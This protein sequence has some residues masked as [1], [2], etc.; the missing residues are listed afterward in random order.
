[1]MDRFGRPVTG[2]RISLA[3][4]S[5]CNF[6]CV[7]CHSEGIYEPAEPVMRPQ[8]IERIVRIAH[9]L[10]VDKVKLTGG[11]PMLRP[12]I[13][14]IVGRV[15]GV[16][17]TDLSMT[18][19]GT[20]LARLAGVLREKGLDRVNIS[21]HSLREERYTFITNTHSHRETMEAIGA[22]VEAGLMPVK[23]NVVVMKGLNDDEIDE[24]IRFTAGLGGGEKV[25]LQLIELIS[26][27]PRFYGVY[28]VDL[29]AI[30]ER[31]RRTA[32]SVTTRRLHNRPRYCLPN[33]VVVEV[34]RPM[35]N[36]SFCAANDRLR[37]THDGKFKPCLMRNDNHVD[38]LTAMRSGASDEELAQLYSTAVAL[39]E[40]FFKPGR[41]WGPSQGLCELEGLTA[42]RSG[43][44][45][46]NTPL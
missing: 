30:E 15:K 12:D 13:M 29:S 24:M 46:P 38:F 28:H 44:P 21:L 3:P 22:S 42:E 19:N 43:L 36:A 40:P 25:I 32:T 9:G 23:L 45:P 5:R 2:L 26:T 34:V 6:D 41:D 17:I 20:R 33:G 8:E 27:Q 4:S 35:H 31:L 16:G 11:E 14:E 37:V 18:T 1:L 7:F 39:R 10:G